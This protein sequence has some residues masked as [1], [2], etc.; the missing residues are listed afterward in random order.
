[1]LVLST[2]KDIDLAL[3]RVSILFVE[4]LIVNG[5]SVELA[6]VSFGKSLKF[7]VTLASPVCQEILV[8]L[9]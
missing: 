2:F 1:M 3:A 5:P 4:L 6:A 7:S 9:F 8:C